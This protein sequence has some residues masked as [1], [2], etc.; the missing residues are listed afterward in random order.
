[1]G[2][3]FALA[4]NVPGTDYIRHYMNFMKSIKVYRPK[5]LIKGE[6]INREGMFVAIPDKGFKDFRVR[7][8]FDGYE[9]LIKNWHKAVTFRRFH[10]KFGG[11]DYTLGYFEWIPI[12]IKVEQFA[13]EETPAHKRNYEE[14]IGGDGK[15]YF[16]EVL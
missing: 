16:R 6:V 14:Y 4:I 10:D 12:E 3:L 11:R 13:L 8:I 7:V 5:F 9:M 2:C 15:R 1:M